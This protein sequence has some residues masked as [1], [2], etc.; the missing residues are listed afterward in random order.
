MATIV[1]IRASCRHHPG[2]RAGA[3]AGYAG[4][5]SAALSAW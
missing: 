3:V 2:R 4:P 5:E 1:T